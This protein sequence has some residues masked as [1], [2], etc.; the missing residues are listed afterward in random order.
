MQSFHPPPAPEPPPHMGITNIINTI[1]EELTHSPSQPSQQAITENLSSIDTPH[2]TPST[3]IQSNNPQF[4]QSSETETPTQLTAVTHQFHPPQPHNRLTTIHLMH[5]ASTCPQ[6]ISCHYQ[7]HIDGGANR[8]ITNDNTQLLH[9]K[10][11]KPYYMPSTSNTNDIKCTGIGYLPWTTP[12]GITLL[13]KCYYSANAADNI[14]SPSDVVINHIMHYHSWTQH[15]DMTTDK[16]HITFTNNDTNNSITYP[17]TAQNGLWFSLIDDYMDIPPA[18]LAIT[19]KPIIHC[20]TNAGLYELIHARMGH[21]GERIMSTLHLHVDGI[22]KLNKLPLHK[23]KTCM[24][25]KATKRAIP[26][27]AT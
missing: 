21:P 17:L 12:D 7:L 9:F 18:T 1:A 20:L 26:N 24:L 2:I 25:V 5:S 10:N 23:C 16:G 4:K 13:I 15:A 11:I 19:N 14:I 27:N 6:R 8:S 3:T 22:P